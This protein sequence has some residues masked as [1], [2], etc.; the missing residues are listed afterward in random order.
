MSRFPHLENG[1]V[2]LNHQLS[3][4]SQLPRTVRKQAPSQIFGLGKL[5]GS[6]RLQQPP[7]SRIPALRPTPDREIAENFFFAQVN[8]YFQEDMHYATSSISERTKDTRY[9]GEICK[10]HMAVPAA[11]VVGADV[12]NDRF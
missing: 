1:N 3:L 4:K 8:F 7:E 5:P 9:L 10:S 2:F 6:F 11:E 12:E